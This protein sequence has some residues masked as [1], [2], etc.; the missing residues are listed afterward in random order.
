MPSAIPP[1]P[2]STSGDVAHALAKAGL[3][4]V[5]VF[6]GPAVELFQLFVQSPLQRRQVE[7]MNTVGKLLRHLERRGLDL[8]SLQNNEQFITAVMRATQIALRTH[9]ELKLGALRNALRAAATSRETGDTGEHFYLH[10]VDEL[11]EMHIRILGF[12]DAPTLPSVG[13]LFTV[14][15]MLEAAI[16]D[17]I[18][19]RT[20]YYQLI[21]DLHTRG[22]VRTRLHPEDR[23]SRDEISRPRTTR[24]GH[25]FLRFIQSPAEA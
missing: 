3:S 7:W 11:S 14:P 23:L 16:P 15:E 25:D 13:T 21:L 9:S 2:Q 8:T 12:L 1:T 6:G 19:M 24:L 10:L 5:P 18:Q 22:L 20:L 17:L 4:A